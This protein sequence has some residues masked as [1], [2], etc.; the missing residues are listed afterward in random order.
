MAEGG[1]KEEVAVAELV[2]HFL[3]QAVVAELLVDVTVT[4]G[5]LEE[6][7][8]G[9]VHEGAP[10]PILTGVEENQRGERGR[11][12]DV[13]ELVAHGRIVAAKEEGGNLKRHTG[14]G[15]R[16]TAYGMR[17]TADGMRHE[18]YGIR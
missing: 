2:G 9:V 17:H 3:A 16:L 5:Q 6:V 1:K 7:R 10:M 13:S 11:D 15:I 18:A 8:M 4:G 14:G 12:E